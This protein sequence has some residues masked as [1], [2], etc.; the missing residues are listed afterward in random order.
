VGVRLD[1]ARKVFDAGGA[2]SGARFDLRR[3][4]P[5]QRADN[6]ARIRAAAGSAYLGDHAALCRV[7]GRYKL[8]VDTQDLGLSSH[9]LLDGYWEM[10]STEVIA[11]RVH[12]GM[13]VADVGANLG[14]FTALMAD[15]VGPEGAVHAFEPNPAMAE[16]L[17][18]NL[19]IN[20]FARRATVHADPLSDRD[21]EA[22]Q[23]VVHPQF[24]S[25][26]FIVPCK[27]ALQTPP[28]LRTRRFDSFPELAS[29]DFIKIDAEGSEMAIWDGMSGLLKTGR[30]LTILLEFAPSRYADPGG[31]LAAIVQ[32]GFRLNLVDEDSGERPA[33]AAEILAASAAEQMLLLCR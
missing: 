5:E 11:R 33:E 12:P 17:R 26:A 14:Y 24:P 16:R 32:Q 6:E 28:L 20:G 21:G 2:R 23:L 9:L 8:C 25:A 7:L 15:L 18:R 4:S 19:A 13:V 30:S 27:D 29:A 22:V 1:L 31:F 10:W 3:L